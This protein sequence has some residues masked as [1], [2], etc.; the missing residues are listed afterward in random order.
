MQFA[1][2]FNTTQLNVGAIVMQP[3]LLGKVSMDATIDGGITND[4]PS[5][6][7]ESNI[8]SV[9][10]NGYAY[11]NIKIKGELK[12]K[13]FEGNFNVDD[14]NI[15]MAFNGLV[16]FSDTLPDYDFTSAFRANLKPLNFYSED[17]S[18]IGNASMKA[19]GKNVDDLTGTATFGDLFITKG[20]DIYKLD[21]LTITSTYENGLKNISTKS[22]LIDFTISGD[23]IT[24][25][26]PATINHL[27]NYYTKNN[28]SVDLAEQNMDFTIRI[29]NADRLAAIFYPDVQIIRNMDISGNINTV[30]NDF[31]TRVRIQQL[32]YKNFKF[33]TILFENKTV[34]NTLQFF[35]HIN[36]TYYSA[37][38]Y[39]PS[40]TLEGTFANNNLAYVLKVGRDVDSNRLDLHGEIAF[41]KNLIALKILP[42]EIYYN[43]DH[44]EIQANN[45]LKIDNK[46][47]IA[48]NFTLTSGDQMISLSSTADS[49]YNTVLKLNIKN[50]PVNDIFE[51]FIL[52]GE[53]VSGIM[54]GQVTI[55][56]VFESPTFIGGVEINEFAINGT[57]YGTLKAGAAR[58]TQSNKIKITAGLSGKY[59][60][61]A[62]GFYTPPSG[63]GADNLTL[64]MQFTGTPLS[65][66][67]PFM[68]GI[69]SNL[70][71]NIYGDLAINGSTSTLGMA[72]DLKIQKGAAKIDYIG[73]TYVFDVLTVNIEK[74]KISIP[75]QPI[76]DE[77]NNS[78]TLEGLITYNNFSNWDFRKFHLASDKFE[79]MKL[80][81]K[82]NPDF[83]GYAV[84]KVDAN[85]TGALDD[86][87]IQ[88]VTTPTDSVFYLPAYASNNVS[89]HDFIKFINVLNPDTVPD[90]F[91]L[92]IVNVDLVVNITPVVE[93]KILIN[94]EGTEYLSGK[95]FGALHI[96]ANTIGKV[97]IDGEMRITE[98]Y[99]DFSFQNLFPRRFIIQPGGSIH[100][101][102]DP[103]RARFDLVASS[104]VP[105]VSVA[106]LTGTTTTEEID[107]NVLVKITGTLET[108]VIN[109]D[110]D[111]PE[112]TSIGSDVQRS[113]Q[114]IKS[115]QNELNKQVFGLLITKNF[116]PTDLTTY[117]PVGSTVNNT[118][119]DFIAAQLSTY[120]SSVLNDVLK[121]AEV[122][123]GIKKLGES[124]YT[125]V[126]GQQIDL[127]LKQAITQKVILKVGTT[128]S[129][130]G[131]T[132]TEGAA[133][134]LAG[135]FE[136][137]F[138]LTEDGRVRLKAF[139]ISEYDAIIAKNDVKTGVG[140]YYTKDFNKFSELF[141]R[142]G[143]KKKKDLE[144][145]I[146]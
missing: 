97:T 89:K 121:N 134:N 116:L 8:R 54:N 21:T 127:S 19:S 111:V 75:L 49:I 26:I 82:E 20:R 77:L 36:R 43:S 129:D 83:W 137:E 102:G 32:K 68:R 38:D 44:W 140:I 2:K 122:D 47:L 31:N 125:T 128:Y 25:E 104:T 84:G 79:L 1:G 135:D 86:L 78:G 59:G 64:T 139:R 91:N 96:T 72:G 14:P 46:N 119:N 130:V 27:I 113:I 65:L 13:F 67:E 94:S 143:E 99:Y 29:K 71:G 52:P 34:D 57:T 114:Q 66:A 118:M 17:V 39:L 106:P 16:D 103:Y 90:Q 5:F 109:F 142:D 42:S 48:E 58:V 85:I 7:L 141:K 124:G 55:G 22:D 105:G 12:N 123:V 126:Q 133:S 117:N 80:T 110:I 98:G 108:P 145:E 37:G 144:E 30:Q 115:D 40:T 132:T 35:A 9:E 15:V 136:V 88:V 33:D 76:K 6:K 100:F 120:F 51:A 112:N 18:I 81:K 63:G 138:I 146:K 23:F 92:S 70:K 11:S 107:V 24:S 101:D 3:D 73:S 41:E 61:N 87:T 4:E 93:A 69:V 10:F 74:N 28:D 60:F 50:I 56:N 95:G 131:T 45:S 53:N 62:N